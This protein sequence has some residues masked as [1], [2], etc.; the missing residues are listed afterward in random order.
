MS[1][2]NVIKERQRKDD[3]PGF[4]LYSDCIE[5]L[6]AQ[7]GDAEPPVYLCLD[8]LPTQLETLPAGGARMTITMPREMAREL[9]LLPP[10]NS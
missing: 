3:Q 4:Q 10:E 9:G 1:T 2:K 6:I 5:E 8:G 7:D